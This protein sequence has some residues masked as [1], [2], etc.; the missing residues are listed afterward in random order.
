[1]VGRPPPEWIDWG[2]DEYVRDPPPVLSIVVGLVGICMGI[3]AIA[4]LLESVW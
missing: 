1:M 4:L 2:R 3:V